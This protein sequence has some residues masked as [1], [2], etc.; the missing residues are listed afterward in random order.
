LAQPCVQAR[1]SLKLSAK[2]S[3]ARL[4]RRRRGCRPRDRQSAPEAH[5]AVGRW[6][7]QN[8][9]VALR[10]RG[11]HRLSAAR[12]VREGLARLPT[13]L[14]G[15]AQPRPSPRAP[16]SSIAGNRMSDVQA[17]LRAILSEPANASV[18][19]RFARFAWAVA[20]VPRR[21]VRRRAGRPS[22][23]CAAKRP[24]RRRSLDTVGRGQRVR[25]SCAQHSHGT[26]C[27][28]RRH[29]ACRRAWQRWRH[30]RRR[31]EE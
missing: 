20:L 2:R 28:R 25:R 27:D 7:H 17:G 8:L 18:L 12:T 22:R 24:V 3:A 11:A 10:G 31:R 30:R 15:V 13:A 5:S 21:C 16:L 9:H 29:G 1:R 23:P 26:L 6:R 19:V 14:H 4:H